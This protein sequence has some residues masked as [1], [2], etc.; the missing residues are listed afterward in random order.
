[1]TAQDGPGAGGEGFAPIRTARLLLRPVRPDD[2]EALAARRSDPDVAALQSW[3]SPYP[4]ERARHMIAE[5]GAVDHPRDGEWWMLTIAEADDT[6]AIGDLALHLGWDGRAVEIGY[7]LARSAWG[8]GYAAEA[9]AGLVGRLWESDRVTRIHAAM[10]PDNVASAQ[11]LERTGFTYEGRTRLSYWVGEDNTD[12]LLYGMTR[13]DHDSWIT[14]PQAMPDTVRLVE[15][16][17]DNARAVEA[18]VTH[19]SQ[20]RFVAPVLCS[21][22][23]AL[24]RK[25]KDGVPVVPWYRAIDADGELAGFV[26]LTAVTDSRPEP[27][28]W[29]LLVDR[30]HQRRGIGVQTLEAVVEVCRDWGAESLAVSWVEGRGSPEPFYR[31]HGFVPT[32]EVKEDEV[33][34]RLPLT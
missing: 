15:I 12:D 1:M 4:L 14:R 30:R 10:H 16:T 13:A 5:I 27:Y 22:A 34:A 3:T 17:P 19:K 32:G 25:V 33:V 29:R 2:A 18:L 8:Q 26:M 31:R 6:T 11:V 9:V 21:F 20:E 24:I 23:D 7:T 28:L